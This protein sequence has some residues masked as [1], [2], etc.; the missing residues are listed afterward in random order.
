M[1]SRAS[2][3]KS[4]RLPN[5]SVPVGH[6]ATQAGRLPFRL[7]SAQKSH[8]PTRGISA[9]SHSYLGTLN[10]TRQKA[11]AATNADVL[12]VDDRTR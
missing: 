12:V 3:N 11:V 4:A 10:G 6:A 7:R 8:L 9:L 5:F 2:C 1:R